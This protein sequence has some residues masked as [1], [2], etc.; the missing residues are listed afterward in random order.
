MAGYQRPAHM[1]DCRPMAKLIDLQGRVFGKLTVY[2]RDGSVRGRPAW[3]CKCTCGNW[4]RVGGGQLSS[5]DTNSC[6]C[7]QREWARSGQSQ[8][9]HGARYTTEYKIWD[10]IK[11]RCLN[12]NERAYPNY[13]GC[14]ITICE[15]W[16]SSF[17]NFLA[18]M[19]HRPDVSYTLDR[20]DN[21]G[22]Y[23]PANCRWA[24]WIE[25]NNNQRSN[26]RIEHNGMLLSMADWARLLGI[27]YSTFKWYVS[28]GYDMNAIAAKSK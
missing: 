7:L 21:D 2:Q 13:G 8:K 11:Q 15:R 22:P 3:S 19:G 4:V 10:G 28:R 27:N 23:S 16:K 1:L 25:Q 24:T 17:E 18:D 14:G 20:R 6:G 5:G 9:T 26:V 12:K